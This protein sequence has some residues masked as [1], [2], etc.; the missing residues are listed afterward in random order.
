MNYTGAL[1]EMLTLL[2][3]DKEN[4]HQLKEAPK[5]GLTIFWNTV[6]QTILNVDGKDETLQEGDII[7]LTEFHKVNNVTIGKGRMIQFNRPFY[8]I[9]THDHEVSCKG[10][11]FFGSSQVP[12]INIPKGKVKNFELLWQ[13]FLMEMEEM[14]SLQPEM[15]RMLLK[16][17]IILTT[18]LF[19][20]QYN[21]DIENKDMDIIREFNFLV[22]SHFKTKH[23]VADYATLLHKSPKTLS[24]LFALVYSKSPLQIIKER[25]MIEARR[26]LLYSQDTI[27]HIAYNIGYEDVQTFSRF[28]KSQEGKSPKDFR[29][30]EMAREKMPTN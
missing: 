21:P 30:F 27:S 6:G 13:T 2:E 24:N 5:T 20:Q 10:I 17:F 1:E 3:I 29:T 19:K 26:Q 11:L 4:C 15:L 22:E 14:D 16:R 18:R 9:T 25:K 23:K 28:F 12:I 8:C 7:F